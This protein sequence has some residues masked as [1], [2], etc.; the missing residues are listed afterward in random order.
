M[1][2]IRRHGAACAAWLFLFCVAAYGQS[3]Q[4]W[5]E[6]TGV[7]RSD[8]PMKV[9]IKGAPGAEVTFNVLQSCN[10]DGRAS[11]TSTGAC[12][13]P[14][15][16]W[17]VKLQFRDN[18]TRLDFTAHPEIPKGVY[19]T[20]EAFANGDRANG[21][22]MIFALDQG[23]CTLWKTLFDLLRRGTCA[24]S[25]Q[26]AFFKTY[27]P[28]TPPSL[29]ELA[30]HIARPDGT[31]PEILLETENATG[32]A[33]RG[34]EGLWVTR[35]ASSG[36]AARRPVPVESGLYLYDL[37]AM[38]TKKVW[39][40]GTR[41]PTAP[42]SLSDGR[43]AFALQASGS[44]PAEVIVWQDQGPQLR[45]PVPHNLYRLVAADRT[46][47]RIWG[48][49]LRD[50]GPRFV[51]IDL[52]ERRV[53][54]WAWNESAYRAVG[55]SPDG[56]AAIVERSNPIGE[57]DWDLRLITADG[58]RDFSATKGPDILAVWQPDGRKVAF[59]KKDLRWEVKRR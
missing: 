17:K 35:A 16:S 3:I 52:A 44:R 27:G 10:G 13:S 22:L 4:A 59:L 28:G 8:V 11:L 25:L 58:E 26:E 54:D 31:D 14:V 30:V 24:P 29:E 43:V 39:A 19:L 15:Y 55:S 50:D 23:D 51:E 18:D 49:T 57:G 48:V 36:A 6:P 1:K 34:N 40:A 21:V 41:T 32:V 56:R 37:S 20:L 42:L 46:G 7:Q 53:V 2:N 47:D 5:L 38:Q 12:Q 9:V 45:I 33:W